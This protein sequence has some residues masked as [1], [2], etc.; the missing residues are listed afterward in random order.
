[1]TGPEPLPRM[2]PG[3]GAARRPSGRRGDGDG[4]IDHGLSPSLQ[5]PPYSP[6]PRRGGGRL[7]PARCGGGEWSSGIRR[8]GR[9]PPFRACAG[10]R[11]RPFV[12][13]SSSR[14]GRPGGESPGQKGEQPC[15]S[16]ACGRTT[17]RSVSLRRNGYSLHCSGRRP[18]AP[19][20][21][22]PVRVKPQEEAKPCLQPSAPFTAAANRAPACGSC[23]KNRSGS[24]ASSSMT[25]SVPSRWRIRSTR[26]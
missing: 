2:G 24:M 16:R 4:G 12:G 25:R 26:A 18:G 1:M 7:V 10:V 13:S 3:V 9:K 15:A 23:S 22:Q 11:V 19:P 20:P 8:R 21:P 5:P 6:S 14:L 17:T